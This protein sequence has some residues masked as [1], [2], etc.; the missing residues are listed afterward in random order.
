MIAG[1]HVEAGESQAETAVREVEEET[2]RQVRLFA[3]PSPGIPRG[4][5]RAVLP[6]PWWITEQPVPPDPHLAER[7]V[8]VD[9]Q[10]VALADSPA[11]VVRAPEHPF[12][13]A[14]LDQLDELAMFEDTRLLARPLFELMPTLSTGALDA[15]TA[16]SVLAGRPG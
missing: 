9:H 5:P 7:H 10:Y 13:W 4:F 1:G 2:G 3:P 11:Q 6:M 8:H 14:A 15:A 16:L 12:R